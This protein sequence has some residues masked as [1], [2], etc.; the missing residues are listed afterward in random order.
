MIDNLQYSDA[1]LI[2]RF[3]KQNEAA[4]AQAAGR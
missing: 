1:E 3:R 4:D 2:E